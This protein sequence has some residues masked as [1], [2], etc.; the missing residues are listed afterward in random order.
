MASE[1]QNLKRLLVKLVHGLPI[2]LGCMV[3]ALGMA[4]LFIHKSEPIYDSAAKMRLDDQEFGIS[5]NQLYNDFD[6]FST[7]NRVMTEV[8]VVKSP[9]IM[10]RVI[11]SLNLLTE[12]REIGKYQRISLYGK[13]PFVVNCIDNRKLI[14]DVYFQV[15]VSKNGEVE[16]TNPESG[17]KWTGQ[18]GSALKVDGALLHIFQNN[19]LYPDQSVPA[20]LYEVVFHNRDKLIKDYGGKLTASASDKEVEIIRVSFK[21]NSAKLT[22]DISNEI[23]KQYIIDFINQKAQAA[24][25]TIRFIDSQIEVA[26]YKLDNIER[27]LENYKKNNRVI[28]TRQ[29]TETKLRKV[30]NLN[31]QLINM[32]MQEKSLNEL[33]EYIERGAYFDE[34]APP[35]GF[36][37]LLFTELMKKLEIYRDQRIDLLDI[38]TPESEKVLAIEQKMT[39]VVGYLREAMNSTRRQLSEQKIKLEESIKEEEKFFDPLPTREKELAILQREFDIQERT[40]KFLTEKRIEASLSEAVNVAFH[41]VIQHAVVPKRPT[42]P[43]VTLITFMSGMLG[44]LIGFGIVFGISLL[45]KRVQDSDDIE[46]NSLIPVGGTL[47]EDARQT[48]SFNQLAASLD[49]TSKGNAAVYTITS[50]GDKEGKTAVAEGLARA[51]GTCGYTTCL[52]RY[53]GKPGNLTIPGV[54]SIRLATEMIAPGKAEDWLKTYTD[55]FERVVVDLRKFN[56]A[57]EAI[58]LMKQASTSIFVAS[59]SKTAPGTLEEADKITETYKLENVRWV[60]YQPANFKYAKSLMRGILILAGQGWNKIKQSLKNPEII[61]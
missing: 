57:P 12:Y 48:A 21:H 32:E 3:L 4:K 11:D 22:A 34:H 13:N 26:E 24:R 39:E 50:N 30:S 60:L 41:R 2:I 36:G 52:I 31:V 37:D 45:F 7:D 10:G 18:M 6:M 9:A 49:S 40:Y 19:E 20:K 23:C 58:G 35:I 16:F 15:K 54:K 53:D 33:S 38:Y 17:K 44:L 61:P 25:K 42:S 1:V 47:Y 8:E 46:R 28:N 29:E 27:K 56:D 5:N 59:A 51:F 55:T 43:N 14:E